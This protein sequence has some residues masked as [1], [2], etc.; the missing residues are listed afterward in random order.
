MLL[1][2]EQSSL[3]GLQVVKLSWILP[4]MTGLTPSLCWRA[5]ELS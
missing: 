5:N 2:V 4:W 1:L 3:L